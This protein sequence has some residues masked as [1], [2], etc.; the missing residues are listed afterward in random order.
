MMH[1]IPNYLRKMPLAAAKNFTEWDATYH[2]FYVYL[3][4]NK[5]SYSRLMTMVVMGL[6]CFYA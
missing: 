6:G 1:K 4:K 2:R 3:F 5:L